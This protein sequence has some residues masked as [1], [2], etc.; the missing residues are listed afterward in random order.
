MKRLGAAGRITIVQGAQWG[1]EGKG[2]VV[3]WLCL[4]RSRHVSYVVRTGGVNAGHTVRINGKVF[5]MCQVPCGFVNPDTKL[6]LGPGAYINPEVLAEEVGILE[7]AGYDIL[8]RLYIDLMA[9]LH[10]KNCA[11]AALTAGRHHAIGATGKGVSEAIARK[12]LS[13]GQ[14]GDGALFRNY[15]HASQ[16]QIL[17]TVAMLNSE[18]NQGAEI[19]LEG[20]QGNM[21][22]LH[23]GPWPFTTGKQTCAAT[24]LAEA[25]LSP[26]MNIEIISVVRTYP[27]RVAGNSGP[28]PGEMSWPELARAIRR[29]V[30]ADAATCPG[31]VSEAAL[32]EFESAV[33]HFSTIYAVP[34]N[35]D[36]LDQHTW[37]P[38]QRE[39]CRSGLSE[40][41]QKALEYMAMHSPAH[42]ANV[43]RLF[44]FTTVTHKLRRIAALDVASLRRSLMIDRPDWIFLSF[45]NYEFPAIWGKN[46]WTDISGTYAG[47][48][49]RWLE[50]QTNVPIGAVSTGPELGHV[51][52]TGYAH[53]EEEE[54]IDGE[55]HGAGAGASA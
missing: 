44:E 11:A 31:V 22:D 24:W 51:I 13:R 53:E 48:Y 4:N 10:D 32:L 35:S 8:S 47:A 2:G 26:N 3:A 5:K 46:R 25:G 36:A 19:V 41:H 15:R 6:I 7:K 45:L 52:E 21:L 43:S 49:V 50:S 17:D 39:K 33:R 20:T 12:I 55:S 1:S 27:I 37:T 18:Y 30:N 40:I 34:F 29:K 14:G 38:E 9:G 28:M 23:L 16:Y 54:E 42:L